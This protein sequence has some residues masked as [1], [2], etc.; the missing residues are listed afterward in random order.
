MEGCL[1]FPYHKVASYSK[2]NHI[3]SKWLVRVIWD[4]LE[5]GGLCPSVLETVYIYLGL[6]FL[7]CIKAN[8]SV[9]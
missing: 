3:L 5:I 2:C 6:G 7:A 1:G 9:K 8:R 4:P